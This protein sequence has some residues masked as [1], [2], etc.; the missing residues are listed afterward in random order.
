MRLANCVP[1]Y[2]CTGTR[3]ENKYFQPG[4]HSPLSFFLSLFSFSFF[5]QTDVSRLSNIFF[6]SMRTVEREL[7]L[8]SSRRKEEKIAIRKPE[9][10]PRT[11]IRSVYP[12][13]W[14]IWVQ[15]RAFNHELRLIVQ[16][17]RAPLDRLLLPPM[18]PEN[19]YSHLIEPVETSNS[20]G[21]KKFS[22]WNS[23]SLDTIERSRVKKGEM[24]NS[25]FELS[26][27][28]V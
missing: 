28:H 18:N 22:S 8:C 23:R 21:G 12:I 20:F 1:V 14:P 10:F 19:V 5:F 7:S 15:Q 26:I 6:L 2:C 9:N 11:R 24:N 16:K 3:A 25:P 27:L 4:L 13:T 17:W